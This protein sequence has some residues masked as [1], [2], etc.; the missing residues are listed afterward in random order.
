MRSDDGRIPNFFA[1]DAV[2]LD[3]EAGT[4]KATMT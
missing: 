3:E 4:S 2:V 1:A